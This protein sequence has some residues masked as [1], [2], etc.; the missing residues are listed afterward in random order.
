MAK[1]VASG[2]LSAEAIATIGDGHSLGIIAESVNQDR[3]VQFGEF[4]GIDDA[5][6]F[7]KVWKRDEN[8]VNFVSVFLEEISAS[9]CVGNGFYGAGLASRFWKDDDIEALILEH[10]QNRFSS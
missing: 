7:T 2:H 6:L 5:C 4:N 10:F 1:V 3:N 8:S 9:S